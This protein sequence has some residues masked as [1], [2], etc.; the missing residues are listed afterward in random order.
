MLQA[1]YH[2]GE[3]HRESLGVT[4]EPSFQPSPRLPAPPAPER[5]PTSPATAALAYMAASATLFALMNFFAKLASGSTSWMTVAAVR[6]L[7]GALVAIA[8]A[9]ARGTS[10]VIK[11]RRAMFWRSL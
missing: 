2:K 9:R 11:D 4:L 8:V 5:T 3:T 10:L 7:I 6:A 1:G